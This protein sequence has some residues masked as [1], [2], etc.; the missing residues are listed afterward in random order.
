[1]PVAVANSA[2]VARVAIASDAGMLRAATWMLRNSRLR[3][4]AR[5]TTYP[6]N[7][8]SGTGS[9]TSLVMTSKVLRT[10]R[11]KTGVSRKSK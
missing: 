7:R 6:M 1:M 3:M 11:A 8:N 10:T 9:R 2:Q 4:S 5:S